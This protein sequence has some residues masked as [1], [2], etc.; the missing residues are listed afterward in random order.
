MCWFLT[1][2]TPILMAVIT[3]VALTLFLS[4][5]M[6]Q[7]PGTV[8]AWVKQTAEFWSS[9]QVGDS[10]FLGAVSYLIGQDII[11]VP[12]PEPTCEERF[13]SQVL[14]DMKAI[15][16]TTVT[17]IIFGNDSLDESVEARLLKVNESEGTK[18]DIEYRKKFLTECLGTTPEAWET[19]PESEQFDLYNENFGP[20][21][22]VIMVA[23][24]D[25]YRAIFEEM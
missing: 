6:A 22:T 16:I 21:E 9:G 4:T 15:G 7:D 20:E 11:T 2:K 13:N 14:H 17:Y 23:I 12:E 1:V 8:P 19:M 25:Y 24:N 10:E 3:A 18:Y 5:A